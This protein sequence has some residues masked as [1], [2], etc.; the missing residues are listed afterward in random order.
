M[1]GRATIRLGISPHS[2]SIFV[3]THLELVT[4][5]SWHKGSNFPSVRR[6]VGDEERM[7]PGHWLGLVLYVSCCA[8]T[9]IVG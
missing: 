7:R 3:F 6:L 1:F 2:S 9:L 8:L 5:K 4:L